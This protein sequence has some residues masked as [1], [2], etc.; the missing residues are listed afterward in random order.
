M[1][2]AYEGAMGL[3]MVMVDIKANHPDHPAHQ[4]Y[5]KLTRWLDNNRPKEGEGERD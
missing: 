1:S 5:R 3:W 4:E 2:E